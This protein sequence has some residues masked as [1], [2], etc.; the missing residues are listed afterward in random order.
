MERLTGST[1]NAGR[2]G[3]GT[4]YYR[5]ARSEV[6]F[7]CSS[8][9][10]Q[11]PTALMN[12]Q[13]DPNLVLAIQA[14]YTQDVAEKLGHLRPDERDQL[15]AA[16][17]GVD[18]EE[19]RAARLFAAGKITDTVWDSMWREWQDRRNRIRTT[20]ASL[21]HQ[22]K[23]HITNLDVA[24]QMIA[25]VG[26][27][28]NSL[29][30]NDQKELLRHMISRVVIDHEGSISLE[31]RS[32]FSYLQD[33]TKRINTAQ[34][35][36][37]KDV[38]KRKPVKL[39]SPVSPERNVRLPPCA[40]GRTGFEPAVRDNPH[41]HLAGGPNQPLWHLPIYSCSHQRSERDSNPR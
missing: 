2:T 10:D 13:V 39:T 32:P 6:S 15:Q 38:V 16:L 33:I 18:E 27:V 41:N 34:W 31:L 24:L 22:Q 5:I 4:P 20:L 30:R 35:K 25:Q 8:I 29:E 36:K 17:K 19:G 40:A 11:I 37:I 7:P 21:Q 12:I 3:G 26:M 14:V 1:S 23:T 9:D 28:Y